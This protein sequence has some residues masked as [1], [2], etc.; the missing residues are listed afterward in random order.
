MPSNVHPASTKPRNRRSEQREETRARMLQAALDIMIEDGIRAVRNRAVAQ[1]AGVS[2]GSTTYHFSSI[3]DLII[4][5]FQYWRE[6]ALLTENTFYRQTSE[7]LAPYQD[8]T[9]PPHGRAQIASQILEYAVGYLGNQLSG[10]REDRLLELAFQH[11]SMRY[12]AL[13]EL[14]MQEWQAQFDF[15]TF[16][17]RAMGSS[18]AQVDARITVALFRQLEQTTVIAQLQSPDLDVIRE[19]LHRHLQ[20][21]IGV[22]VPPRAKKR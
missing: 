3:E 4:S 5:A 18:N 1:R 6:G 15:L 13:H 22:D 19:T 10:K 9:V 12:P 17:H 7:L 2:L 16:V 11:E 20:L 14:V 8:T 21:C